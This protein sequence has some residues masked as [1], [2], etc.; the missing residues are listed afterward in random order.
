MILT[1]KELA[2]YLRVNERTIL[3][4][5]QA[6][7]I[8]GVKIG[9]QWRFNGKEIDQMFFPDA[10][11]DTS[12]E[13]GVAL[14]ELTRQSSLQIPISRLLHPNR[15]KLSLE[16]TDASGAIDELCELVSRE[17]LTYAVKDFTQRIH[18]RE[19][20][21]STGVGNGVALPHPRDPVS[22]LQEPAIIIVGKS[23]QGLAFEAIDNAPVHLVFLLACQDIQTH[24]HIMGQMARCLRNEEILKTLFAAESAQEIIQ[25]IMSFE[26]QTFL[27]PPAPEQT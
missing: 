13:H 21:L 9:G 17:N 26:R 10:K 6:G 3:R 27:A 1:L 14:G 16:S 23:E 8:K 25:T 12:P 19:A 11:H 2:Q 4:M 5:H 24:L 22:E 15:M 20:L 7:Q 18:A